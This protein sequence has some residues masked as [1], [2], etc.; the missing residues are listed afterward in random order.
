M[1]SGN[2]AGR[3]SRRQPSIT[4]SAGNTPSS[5]LATASG[6]CRPPNLKKPTNGSKADDEGNSTSKLDL[7]LATGNNTT[8][9]DNAGGSERAFAPGDS[10]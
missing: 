5:F 4:S 1:T 3:A 2:P 8:L 6:S 9:F 10:P 7:A